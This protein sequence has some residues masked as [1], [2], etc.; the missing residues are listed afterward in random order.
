MM[1][2]YNLMRSDLCYYKYIHNLHYRICY[3]RTRNKN[4]HVIKQNVTNDTHP[5]FLKTKTKN[6]N[7]SLI[8]KKIV[9]FVG[10]PKEFT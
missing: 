3:M 10:P 5:S 8:F 1:N 7:R 4:T 2:L 9:L 6:N